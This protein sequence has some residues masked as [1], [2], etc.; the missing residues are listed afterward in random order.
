MEPHLWID[1]EPIYGGLILDER[2]GNDLY[3]VAEGEGIEYA[4]LRD[5][6]SLY[7]K[8]AAL[9][10]KFTLD[11]DHDAALMRDFVTEYG[12]LNGIPGD[13]HPSGAPVDSLRPR[14]Q[15]IVDFG[16]KVRS[17]SQAVTLLEAISEAEHFNDTS[18]LSRMNTKLP[19]GSL[20]Q[21]GYNALSSML[22]ANI[23]PVHLLPIATIQKGRPHLAAYFGCSSLLQVIWLQVY[24]A[25][26]GRRLIK[27]ACGYCGEPYESQDRRRKYCSDS[28]RESKAS[29]KWYDTHKRKT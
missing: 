5:E 8:T 22:R 4:P 17:V 29:K 11:V 28:C 25:G 3:L 19:R 18:G 6:P 26:L 2:E 14:R 7:L 24:E 20:L 10:R 13:T 15:T 16:L 1:G 9:G 27:S 21:W 12:L 23:G